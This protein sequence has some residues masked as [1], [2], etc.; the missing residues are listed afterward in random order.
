MIFLFVQVVIIC[1]FVLY[2]TQFFVHDPYKKFAQSSGTYFALRDSWSKL[3][4][5]IG[6][7][8]FHIT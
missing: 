4:R 3:S 7:K 8:F 1:S 5:R 2:R 6:D